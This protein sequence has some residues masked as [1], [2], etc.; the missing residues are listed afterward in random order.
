MITY[1]AQYKQEVTACCDASASAARCLQTDQSIVF[2]CYHTCTPPS[3]STHHT[4]HS[5]LEL[6]TFSCPFVHHWRVCR[7]PSPCPPPCLLVPQQFKLSL[8]F[9]LLSK[10][11]FNTQ[12]TIIIIII[13]YSFMCCY[14]RL[15]HIAH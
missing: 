5:A 7:P 3:S 14:S 12:S 1:A 11:H 2:P 6:S 9:I 13:M 4:I 8:S 10:H 15:E